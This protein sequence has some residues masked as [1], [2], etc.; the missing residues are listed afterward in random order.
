MESSS[1]A[2]PGTK[3]K[4]PGKGLPEDQWFKGVVAGM[5]HGGR[6]RVLLQD[7]RDLVRVRVS[8]L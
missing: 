1:E 8:V 7:G 5:E 2:T 3:K 4:T 6:Q